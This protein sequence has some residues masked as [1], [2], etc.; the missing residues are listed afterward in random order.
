MKSVLVQLDD[1][2]V[3]ALDRIAPPRERRRSEFIR[4]ALKRAIR[5]AEYNA[6]RKAYERLPDSE[7]DAD[8][9]SNAEEYKP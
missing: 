6:M 7:T 8:D 4:N 9:W 5:Q 2:T 3:R 1:A